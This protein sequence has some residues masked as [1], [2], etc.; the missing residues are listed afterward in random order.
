MHSAANR[1]IVS[2]KTKELDMKKLLLSV[3]A[4]LLYGCGADELETIK[5]AKIPDQDITWG[6]ATEKLSFCKPESR[7]WQPIKET[8]QKK[9]VTATFECEMTEA[10]IAPYNEM[11]ESRIQK[12]TAEHQQWKDEKLQKIAEDTARRRTAFIEYYQRECKKCRALT[13]A[14]I[15]TLAIEFHKDNMSPNPDIEAMRKAG[16]FLHSDFMTIGGNLIEADT[17]KNKDTWKLPYHE[18]ITKATFKLEVTHWLT[19]KDKD[20]QKEYTS[21]ADVLYNTDD[22]GH[23]SSAFPQPEQ[24]VAKNENPIEAM[25]KEKEAYRLK[26]PGR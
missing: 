16:M 15:D 4:C 17:L 1:R 3:L 23:S 14:E 26:L 22:G 11:Q 8:D 19:I 24:L 6:A 20:L 25:V 21:T 5:N 2:L 7:A 12:E 9:R 18:K 10:A 13:D